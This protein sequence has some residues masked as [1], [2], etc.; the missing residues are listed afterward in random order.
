M[1]QL[2][3]KQL[4][5]A[6][7]ELDLPLELV[8]SLSCLALLGGDSGV[9]MRVGGVVAVVASVLIGKGGLQDGVDLRNISNSCFGT[10]G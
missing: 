1:H 9:G 10:D 4:I 7:Q 5:F 3:L 2:L 6:L 8:V